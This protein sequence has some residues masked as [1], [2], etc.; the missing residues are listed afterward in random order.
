MD[1]D[2]VEA[3]QEA[4]IVPG[5]TIKGALRI[6][7]LATVIGLIVGT[8]GAA[9]RYSLDK[10]LAM[11]EEIASQFSSS[12]LATIVAALIGA[13]MVAVAFLL[14]RRFAPE[15]A[16][17]GIQEVE[18][19]LGGLREIRWR[20]V[21][22]VKFV[23]GVLAI[24]SGL[25]LGREG[26]TIHIGGCV[27]RMVGEKTRAAAETMNTLIAAGAAAG[28]SA[29]FSAPLAG[30]FFVTEEMQTRFKYTFVSLHAIV[31]A[32]VTANLAIEEVFGMGPALPVH[33]DVVLPKGAFPVST[34]AS[35]PSNLILG[36]IMG[37]CGVGFNAVMLAWLRVTDRL[38]PRT[39]LIVASSFGALAG[40]LLITSQ[41]FVCGGEVMVQEV[42]LS[43]PALG[44]LLILIAVRVPMTFL[45]YSAGVPGGIFAPMLALG[46]LIGFAF[47]HFAGELIPS[48]DMNAGAFAVAAMGGLF[49][50]TVRAPLTG[51]VLVAE[52]TSSF[53]LL[54]AMIITCVTASITAQWLGSKPIYE[55]LLARTLANEGQTVEG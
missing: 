41:K 21:L 8:L 14:V 12:V 48:N 54:P 42:F 43:P 15:A 25:V 35:V 2:Q 52:L 39:M 36:V 20:R 30:V 7:L 11:H 22:P 33:L 40:A 50:A 28:L 37:I 18:G 23:S 46:T 27:S 13:A 45:S 44:M 55:S 24:G 19:A 26:P 34:L 47:G 3:K 29:A 6:Y 4:D 53:Q 17:S 32:S 49:A 16:G 1:H 51:I 38:S 10:A 9:F 31:I 5:V